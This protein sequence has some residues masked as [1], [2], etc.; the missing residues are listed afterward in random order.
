ML[1]K[2]I[3]PMGARFCNLLGVLNLRLLIPPGQDNRVLVETRLVQ[4]P[5][6]ALF[7]ELNSSPGPSSKLVSHW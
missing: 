3:V 7:Q 4:L 1:M 6:A 2:R 5:G